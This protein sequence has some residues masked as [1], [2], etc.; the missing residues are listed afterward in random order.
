VLIFHGVGGGHAIDVAR[1]IH[2]AICRE[3][4]TRRE[5]VW[6]DTFL[7]IAQHIRRKSKPWGAPR[8]V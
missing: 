6:C 1:D 2:R 4:A 8:R 3:L 7:N 5:E